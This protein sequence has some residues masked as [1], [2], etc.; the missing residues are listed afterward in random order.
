MDEIH[1]DGIFDR[2]EEAARPADIDKV[3]LHLRPLDSVGKKTQSPGEYPK[4]GCARR[5]I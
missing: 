5:F 1:P 4:S 3:P 2:G